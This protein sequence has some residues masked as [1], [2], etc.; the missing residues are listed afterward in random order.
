MA[1]IKS[2]DINSDCGESF[3][4]WKMGADEDLLPL[5][6]TANVACG[7]HAGD[8]ATMLRTVR[9]AEENGVAVG[10]HPGLPDLMGFGR[11]RMAITPEEAYAYVHYQTGALRSLLEARGLALHHVKPHGALYLMLYDDDEL[12]AAV[13]QAID[14]A[15]PAPM[16]YYP[17][18]TAQQALPKAAAKR[19]IRVIGEVYFDLPYDRTGKLVLE[20]KKKAL[21]LDDLRRRVRDYITTGEVT[22]ITG[23]RV[24]IPAESICVHGDGPNAVE[25][26]RTVRAVLQ[27]CGCA[28]E[29]VPAGQT[30]RAAAAS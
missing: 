10:S 21:D 12:A 14:E 8:P 27:E 29:A 22:A 4:N 7:Y 11:R 13:A 5:I 15:C 17:A 18:P 28:V 2:I 23:E 16:L 6:T 25:V 26:V 24:R 1:M 19:G 9:L 3:G 30:K 20:R